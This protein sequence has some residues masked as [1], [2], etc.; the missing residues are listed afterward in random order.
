M[1]GMLDV[2]SQGN[3]YGQLMINEGRINAQLTEQLYQLV[4]QDANSLESVPYILEFKPGMCYYVIKNLSIKR[5]D[6]DTYERVKGFEAYRQANAEIQS[7]AAVHFNPGN[8]LKRMNFKPIESE[9]TEEADA[10]EPEEANGI[11]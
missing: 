8:I 6:Q 1:F 7:L 9:E 3:P 5:L 11:L 4:P 2:F 10:N